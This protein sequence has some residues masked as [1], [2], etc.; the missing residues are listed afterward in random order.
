MLTDADVVDKFKFNLEE[1]SYLQ[2]L[3]EYSDVTKVNQFLRK[4]TN[5]KKFQGGLQSE[6][7]A[8]L[9]ELPNLKYVNL[10][11]DQNELRISHLN[12]N[13]IELST[14]RVD[15]LRFT[16]NV[17]I[18]KLPFLQ[19]TKLSKI[20]TAQSHPQLEKL[21][22]T[23]GN[24]CDLTEISL[25]IQSIKNV[26][27]YKL[28]S[29]L[30]NKELLLF[31]SANDQI[32]KLVLTCFIKPEE[33][34]TILKTLKNLQCLDLANAISDDVNTLATVINEFGSKL[35]YLKIPNRMDLIEDSKN[36]QSPSLK[37]YY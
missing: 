18:L 28:Y 8:V 36:I 6:S 20:L 24:Y 22:I 17:K 2:E 12:R 21:E 4:Q 10:Y 34:I 5:L 26:V 31:I 32:E 23:L 25:K 35:Q 7:V 16:P 13:I 19:V 29:R 14:N 30:S 27:F 37:I 1:L 33:L 15:L 11:T 9:L 3:Y